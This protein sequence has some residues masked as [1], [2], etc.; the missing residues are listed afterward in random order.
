M[1][2]TL[3]TEHSALIGNIF[4]KSTSSEEYSL[5]QRAIQEEMDKFN[6][7]GGKSKEQDTSISI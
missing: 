7:L 5:S 2:N 4:D 3:S 6:G 1:A